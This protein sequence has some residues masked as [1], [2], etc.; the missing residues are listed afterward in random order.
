ML[1]RF[2]PVAMALLIMVLI[3]QSAGSIFA[4]EA[5][6]SRLV[7]NK[8]E[9]SLEAGEAVSL[10]A[11][12]VYVTGSTSDVTIKTDWS[13]GSPEVA[14]VYAGTIT[15]K[16][17]G[18]AVITATYLGKTVIVNVTV[19]KKVKALTMNVNDFDLRVGKEKQ[20]ELTAIYEDGTSEA[21]T[22]KAAWSVDNYSVA[23]VVNGLVTGKKS[24]NAKVTAK[25]GNQ[26]VTV[27]AA[28]E[29]ARRLD[30]AQTEL[31]LLLN[32]EKQIV[33][34][35]TYPDGSTDNVADKAEWKSD[36]EK[37]ADAIN[38]TIKA[39]KAGT[40]TITA[41][42][43]TKSATIEVSVDASRKLEASKQE[44]FLRT[45]TSEKLTL[46][47]TYMDGTKADITDKAKWSSSNEAVAFATNGEISAYKSGE[48]EIT[49]TYGD[50]SVKIHV[51]VEVPK[52]L[53]LDTDTIDVELNAS[54][55][56]KLYATFADGKKRIDYR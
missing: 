36:N 23:T 42:Y 1:S 50:K 45:G 35:A 39:Y 37:V 47:L 3:I 14:T 41:T 5:E 44:L 12:A 54:K 25:Y 18:T 33:L 24:G 21:V 7:L 4:A 26:S 43:G 34:T 51:D 28:V 2:R 17:E 15:A 52:R 22:K 27:E 55:D 6:I 32:E 56:L 10:T 19:S 13:S 40:A 9:V 11:T 38:G 16:K 30:V 8:N 46:T 20:I 31:N 49:A 29:I 48:A 53:D